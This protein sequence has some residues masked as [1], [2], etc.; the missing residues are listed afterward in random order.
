MPQHVSAPA[1]VLRG[2]GGMATRMQTCGGDQV[3]VGLH[4]TVHN[5]AGMAEVQGLQAH[6]HVGLDICLGED[7]GLVLDDGLQVALHKLKHLHHITFKKNQR[8]PVHEDWDHVWAEQ[9]GVL[10]EQRC[11]L[12][13]M[14]G[15]A[16]VT[17]RLA[18]KA[19]S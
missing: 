17:Q 11:V 1:R 4:I 3:I 7:Y 14:L 5:P 15:E 2:G 18:E 19:W 10:I 12:R 13:Y 9:R 16:N 8:E 6:A